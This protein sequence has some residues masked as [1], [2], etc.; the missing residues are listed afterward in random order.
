[1]ALRVNNNLKAINAQRMIKRNTGTMSRQLERLS[2]GM[3]VNRA[4]DDAA[5]L[6]IS[7]SMR[8]EISGLN[9][10]VRNAEHATNLLQV[11]EGSLQEVSGILIRMRELA[12]Q[13][14]SSTMNDANRESMLAEFTQLRTEI[15]RIAE[16]TTYNDQSLLV[17]FGNS[18]SADSTEIGRA[19]V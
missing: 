9:Q 17:G 10:N 15:D 6:S 2:S 12:V 3:R 8:G 13:S 18:A 14:A 7:E 4:A 1:M 5:G 11:A 16:A 19:H